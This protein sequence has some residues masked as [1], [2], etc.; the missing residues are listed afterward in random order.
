[1]GAACSNAVMPAIGRTHHQAWR[2][3]VDVRPFQ[4]PRWS[5][6]AAG[7]RLICHWRQRRN[8]STAKAVSCSA[9]AARRIPSGSSVMLN[10]CAAS[11]ADPAV[12]VRVASLLEAVRVSAAERPRM[13]CLSGDQ[14]LRG[15]RSEQ[16]VA[17]QRVSEPGE[18]P[19]RRVP[20]AGGGSA[21]RQRVGV[22]DRRGCSRCLGVCDRPVGDRFA[23]G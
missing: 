2:D 21:V 15:V 8:E 5:T 18:V 23:V 4:G 19:D 9:K 3:H 1:M 22:R 20:A 12:A 13:V 16:L 10:T 14:E 11:V 6:N 7:E 17:E